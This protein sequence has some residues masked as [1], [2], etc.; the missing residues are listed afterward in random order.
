MIDYTKILELIHLTPAVKL[1]EVTSHADGLSEML[2]NALEEVEGSLDMALYPGDH[3]LPTNSNVKAREIASFSKPFRG[4]PREY[5]SV[6]MVD[7]LDKHEFAERILQLAYKTL[8]NAS[9]VIII[10]DKNNT[11]LPEVL[12]LLEKLDFR[13]VNNIDLID[14]HYVVVGKKMHMWGNGL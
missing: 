3:T 14:S 4:L 7:V 2:C 6:L 5:A 1:L 9:E 12:E 8:L 11:N 13:A 10:Q